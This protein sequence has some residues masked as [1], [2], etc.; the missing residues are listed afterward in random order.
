LGTTRRSGPRTARDILL[1]APARRWTSQAALWW[2]ARATC[3]AAALARRSTLTPPSSASTR[4]PP[5]ACT[6][7]SFLLPFLP[8]SWFSPPGTWWQF[9]P[10]SPWTATALPSP[11]TRSSVWRRPIVPNPNSRVLDSR[12]EKKSKALSHLVEGDCCVCRYAEDVGRF[13]TLRFQNRDRSGYAQ[14]KVRPSVSSCVATYGPTS[15]TSAYPRVRQR[16]YTS[17][18]L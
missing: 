3:S 14:N 5:A 8:F 15:S 17:R 12:H 2:R 18:S 16:V 6:P 9:Y 1:A 7:L 13:S 4:R 11:C 10:I